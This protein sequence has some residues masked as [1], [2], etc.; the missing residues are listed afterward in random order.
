MRISEVLSGNA[1]EMRSSFNPSAA[2]FVFN[3]WDRV[4]AN[5]KN[6]SERDEIKKRELEKLS[7]VWPNIDVEQ[8]VFFLSVTEV[9]K[10]NNIS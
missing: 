8:Q 9:S 4:Q 5:V 1:A 2:L 3:H 7:S 10:L 6:E